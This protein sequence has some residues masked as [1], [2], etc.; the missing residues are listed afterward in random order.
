MG[1]IVG[2]QNYISNFQKQVIIGCLLGDGRL[3]SRSRNNTA[4]LRIHHGE[5]QRDYLFWKYRVFRNIVSG[6]PKKIIWEDKKRNVNC[7]SWYFHSLTLKELGDLYLL[8]YDKGKKLCL[9][10]LMIY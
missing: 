2:R 5:K 8:F 1:N 4:R 7:I 6:S 9:K 3:E 10:I